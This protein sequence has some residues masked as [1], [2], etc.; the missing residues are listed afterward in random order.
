MIKSNLNREKLFQ[1]FKFS[2]I[3]ALGFL[4]DIITFYS[5]NII[6]NTF[7]SRICS[8][9]LAVIFTY[10][11]NK[12]LTF[13]QIRTKN[14]FWREFVPYFFSMLLGGSINLLTFFIIETSNL[15][16]SQFHFISIALGSCAGLFVNFFLSVFIF[17]KNTKKKSI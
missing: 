7:F 11:C 4:V 5:L 13:R 2:I 8:F 17:D 14:N 1:F 12:I 6:F 9:L 15:F 3:G 10:I 16:F